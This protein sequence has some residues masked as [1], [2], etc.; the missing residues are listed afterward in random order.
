MLP[1]ERIR[2]SILGGEEA[3]PEMAN[4]SATGLNQPSPVG[5]FLLGG[6]PCGCFDMTG[7]VWEWC[8]D[9]VADYAENSEKTVVDPKGPETGS[10][11]VI[12]GGGWINAA[13]LLPVCW[14]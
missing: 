7:N 1:G 3:N 8:Y 2:E 9:W 11:R 5:C 12:R 10:I 6:S 4:Y 14:P 13:R